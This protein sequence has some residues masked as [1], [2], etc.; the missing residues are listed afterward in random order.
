MRLKI[1]RLRRLVARQST[2]DEIEARLTRTRRTGTGSGPS[3]HTT[4]VPRYRAYLRDEIQDGRYSRIKSSEAGGCGYTEGIALYFAEKS[5]KTG[6]LHLPEG[7]RVVF[8]QFLSGLVDR[9]ASS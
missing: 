5:L 7:W 8:A 1:Q 4:T 9:P 6:L 2:L 3:H